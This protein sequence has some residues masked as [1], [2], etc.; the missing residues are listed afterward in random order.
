MLVPMGER[1][2]LSEHETLEV[3][4][5]SADC[6]TVEA[7]YEPGG[8]KPPAHYHPRQQERFEVLTGALSVEVDGA[9]TEYAAGETFVVEPGQVHR[10]WNGGSTATTA[11]WETRPALGT[12]D[13]F[14]GLDRLAQDARAKGEHRPDLLGFARHAAGHR[15]TFRLVLGGPKP[16]GDIVVRVLG[17]AA[18]SVRR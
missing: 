17:A 10:M 9:V 2:R 12:I 16:F 13:W 14:R 4:D 7:A 1:I 15:D 8:A 18:G 11:R 5:S 3:T 6:L